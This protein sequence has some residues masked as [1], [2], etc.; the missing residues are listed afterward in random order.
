MPL[1]FHDP[2]F[3]K[4]DESVTTQMITHWDNEA[5]KKWRGATIISS[6]HMYEHPFLAP[7]EYG[8][9]VVDY[10]T[11]TIITCQDYTDIDSVMPIQVGYKE[12]LEDNMLDRTS[13]KLTKTELNVIETSKMELNQFPIKHGPWTVVEC[14]GPPSW[15]RDYKKAK[16]EIEKLGFVLTETEQKLWEEAINPKDEDDLKVEIIHRKNE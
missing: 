5:P 16:V 3:W 7:S 6:W 1:F 14:R 8:I 13:E 4:G 10:K 2:K 11:M 12:L 15:Q 9:I